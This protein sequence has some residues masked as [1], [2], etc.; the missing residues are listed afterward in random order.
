VSEGPEGTLAFAAV[1]IPV[2][3]RKLFVYEV[4]VELRSR[5]ARGA[6]VRVPFGR[7]HLS[8]TVVEWP[9]PPPP[10]TVRTKR[11]EAILGDE[12]AMSADLLDLTRFV[13][14]YYLCSWGEAIET[15]MPPRARAAPRERWVRR[16]R[17]AT[18]SSIPP[19]ASAQRRTFDSLPE[20]G[21]PIELS[22]LAES[23]R[24]AAVALA[25]LGLVEIVH[26]ERRS[27]HLVTG[28][29]EREEAERLAPTAA[30]GEVL[31]HLLPATQR[32][33]FAPFLLFGATGSG[34]TEVYLRA[35]EQAL[36]AGR[37]VLYL[38]PEIGLT[39]LLVSKLSTRFPGTVA[40]LHSG[41]RPTDR[42]EAWDRIRRGDRRL[43]VGARSAV[44]APISS[45]GLI[46]VDE[47]QDTSYK[48]GETPRYNGRDVAVVRARE[49]R[50]ALVLGSATP[51]LESFRHA[52]AGRYQLL[53]LGGRVE[54]RPLPHVHIVDMRLEY[55]SAGTI[56]P[57]SRPLL[58]ALSDCVQRGEQALILR[59]RRGWATSLLCPDC[60]TRVSCPNCSVTMTW[61]RSANRLR[62]HYCDLERP[63]PTS[64]PLCGENSFRMLGEGT[65]RIEDEVRQA[66]PGVRLARMD[67]DTVRR[68]GAQETLLRRFAR[69]EIDVLVGT[70]MIAK[71]H[72]FPNVTL[73]GVLSADQSLGLPDFRAAERTFQ[74]LTQVAGR[75]GRGAVPGL[76]IVQAFEPAHA[77]LKAA[78]KQDYERF[79]DTEIAYRRSLRYPPATALVELIVEDRDPSRAV[80]WSESIAAALR[81]ESEG[82]LMLSG[83]GPA[84]IE[85]LR[86]K[87]RRQILVR[88]IGRRRLVSAVGRALS[89]VE[90]KVPRR[91]IV[92]DVDPASIL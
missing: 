33:E 26:V 87:F 37:G 90:G 78:A 47:E 63:R 30:Q 55:R 12:P 17:E 80:A 61:H 79:Y 25:K 52:Q 7:R 82:R 62:C 75:A 67:R 76:V 48:Q 5:L 34:K 49:Q 20:D 32:E 44:F 35:A 40:V 72:D 54:N 28:S 86:G 77:V 45:T 3:A 1:A 64:C 53:R 57:L 4:P 10:E 8:G 27:D 11:I 22:R 6:R 65:E 19:R 2:P 56:R 74:L 51:S 29:A 91:A 24:R 89:R 42:R 36:A 31:S 15:A 13:A 60:G 70:Q 23:G 21:S 69:R 85:R 9:S 92:V 83:P 88:S 38:V 50:C 66:R 71:G 68:R 58:A 46:V 18:S 41:L 59:N 73:V 16:G 84:P 39:P 81:E 43:V 14:D